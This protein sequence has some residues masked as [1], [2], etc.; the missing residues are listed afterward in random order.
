MVPSMPT[1]VIDPETDLFGLM[2]IVPV[3]VAAVV[4]AG[5][6]WAPV[7][8]TVKSAESADPKPPRS[9][10]PTKAEV[11]NRRAE[12]GIF[13]ERTPAAA[14]TVPTQRFAAMRPPPTGSS[15]YLPAR[16]YTTGELIACQITTEH[17]SV[18]SYAFRS[19]RPTQA[20]TNLKAAAARCVILGVSLA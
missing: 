16:T 10:A 17:R 20:R 13:I 12:L 4:T 11:W 3:P 15:Y 6:S 19:L 5:T 18:V 2:M 8:L 1:V 7:S 14:R 9:N